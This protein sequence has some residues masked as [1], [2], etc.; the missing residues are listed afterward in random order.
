MI[1]LPPRIINYEWIP[2]LVGRYWRLVYM[3]TV[4]PPSWGSAPSGRARY[5]RC[6]DSRTAR[7]WLWPSRSTSLPCRVRWF[8]PAVSL[9]TCPSTPYWTR[10]WEPSCLPCNTATMIGSSLLSGIIHTYCSLYRA[11]KLDLDAMPFRQAEE[12]LRGTC[13]VQ[14]EDSQR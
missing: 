3:I 10:T 5:R 12:K 4:E 9:R 13:S 7:A 14:L 11:D 8:S 6:L 2:I 1:G